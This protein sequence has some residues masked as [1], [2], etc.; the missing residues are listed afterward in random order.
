MAGGFVDEYGV[1]DPIF[2]LRSSRRGTRLDLYGEAMYMRKAERWLVA[3]NATTPIEI[4]RVRFKLGAESDVFFEKT[5]RR[6][7]VGPRIVVPL[8]T[9]VSLASA[10]QFVSDGEGILRNY[11]L[12]NVP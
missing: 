1:V 12:I 5:G 3:M 2:N 11:L 4:G 6:Y 10:Y 9:R 7:G 8:S